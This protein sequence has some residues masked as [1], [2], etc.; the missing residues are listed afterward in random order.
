[1]T[2]AYVA[3]VPSPVRTGVSNFFSNVGMPI[4]MANDALQGK[5]K[6]SGTDLGRFLMNSVIGIG[7]IF[8]PATSAGLDRNYNDFGLT[9][10]RWG[11]HPGPFFELP[12]LGP[13]D[14]RDGLG[15]VPDYFLRATYWIPSDYDWVSYSLGYPPSSMP[16]PRSCR[17]NR[18]SIR[19]TTRMR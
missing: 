15:K 5:L 8:D 18:P 17:C 19:R 2:K 13:S 12:I 16:V 6:A 7:G 4:V 10:G 1:M 11:A 9:L 14:V 3:H